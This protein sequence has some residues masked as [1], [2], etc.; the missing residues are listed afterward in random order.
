MSDVLVKDLKKA[1]LNWQNTVG[2]EL[3]GQLE[4]FLGLSIGLIN[5]THSGFGVA[6]HVDKQTAERVTKLL[7]DNHAT[8]IR[9][10]L[11]RNK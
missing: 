4:A 11:A 8:M 7:G 1:V 6:V 9:V 2:S 3:N 10:W 5:D